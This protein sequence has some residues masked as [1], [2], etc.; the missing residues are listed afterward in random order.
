MSYCAWYW[1]FWASCGKRVNLSW[2]SCG[3]S[4]SIRPVMHAP[5]MVN[6]T[7]LYVQW[8]FGLLRGKS[9]GATWKHCVKPTNNHPVRTYMVHL[10]GAWFQLSVV[11]TMRQ[12][13]KLSNR[14][15]S[16]G[17]RSRLLRQKHFIYLFSTGIHT[18]Y[19]GLGKYSRLYML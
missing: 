16:P 7:R 18:D 3:F 6:G 19:N 15:K 4:C 10:C 12:E 14:Q 9:A 17:A 1:S 8:A 2:R 5:L 13:Y 11:G